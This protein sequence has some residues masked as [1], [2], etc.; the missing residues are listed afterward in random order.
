MA[1]IFSRKYLGTRTN[2]WITSPQSICKLCVKL[3]LR[4]WSRRTI[5]GKFHNIHITPYTSWPLN[6]FSK[7]DTKLNKN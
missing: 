2:A 5:I 1:A 6:H 3:F 4:S 7:A